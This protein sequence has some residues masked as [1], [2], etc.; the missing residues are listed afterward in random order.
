MQLPEGN[1][2][3]VGQHGFLG[4]VDAMPAQPGLA[5]ER[6]AWCARRSY[7]KGTKA[8]STDAQLVASLWKRGHTTPFEHV[9]FTLHAFLPLFVQNQWVR[10]RHNSFSILSLRYSEAGDEF[11]LPNAL[12]IQDTKN[13]QGSKGLLVEMEG[14][15]EVEAALLEKLRAHFDASL[16]LYGD[17]RKAGVA[18][19][20]ARIVIPTAAYSDMVVTTNLHSLLHLLTQRLAHDAQPEFTWYAQALHQLLTPYAP[21]VMAA[22]DQG[23]LAEV[24]A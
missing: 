9:V 18:R 24:S 20:Q 4:L 16:A 12:R 14:G 3:R 21:S 17:M 8:T 7:Q 11:Y 6:I 23:L 1:Y 22:F 15:R 13:K 19:E 5:D 10:Y 2:I